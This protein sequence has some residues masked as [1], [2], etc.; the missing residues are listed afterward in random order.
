MITELDP[1]AMPGSF[2][3]IRALVAGFFRNLAGY[4]DKSAMDSDTENLR[5]GGERCRLLAR[6]GAIRRCR[7]SGFKGAWVPTNTTEAIE[8]SAVS[9]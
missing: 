5:A 8:G 4:A 3:L 9:G 6:A 2:E 7:F 1:T